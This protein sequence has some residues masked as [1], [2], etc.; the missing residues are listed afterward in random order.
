MVLE[1]V[2]NNIEK[3]FISIAVHLKN[4]KNYN[5]MFAVL[6]GLGAAPVHRLQ[7]TW[8]LL[9]SKVTNQF[10]ELESLM[11]PSRNMSKYRCLK[12]ENEMPPLVPFVPVI[13]KDLTFLHLGNDTKVEELINFEKMRMI[14]RE[15]RLVRQYCEPTVF[16]NSYRLV[17][18]IIKSNASQKDIK[19]LVVPGRF[20]FFDH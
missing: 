8:K 20:A 12:Q 17:F 1:E 7:Q 14:A 19:L 3:H 13:K 6:S 16:I 15:I 5:S 11:D 18:T 9:P 4:L 10:K 2:F